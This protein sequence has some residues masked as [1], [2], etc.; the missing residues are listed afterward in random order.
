[1]GQ[2][3]L[4]L[5]NLYRNENWNNYEIQ[6]H[7]FKKSVKFHNTKNWQEVEAMGTRL[8]A[9]I[10]QYLIGQWCTCCDLHRQTKKVS[11]K[12]NQ[13]W[14]IKS[15][16]HCL[17]EWN[18]GNNHQQ[19]KRKRRWHHNTT[20]RYAAIRMNRAELCGLSW[21]DMETK[22]WIKKNKMQK[23]FYGIPVIWS[24]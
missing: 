4:N 6:F 24:Y 22:C 17:K 5:S 8:L 9:H 21:V 13:T 19:E 20:E 12:Q 2:N 3:L 7:Q 14:E 10:W 11:N 15:F 18:T 23:Y 1:M 16:Q